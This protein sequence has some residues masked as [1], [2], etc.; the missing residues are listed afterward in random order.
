MRLSVEFI[1]FVAVS[2]LSLKVFSRCRVTVGVNGKVL[3][4]V[5]D[6]SAEC[7]VIFLGVESHVSEFYFQQAVWIGH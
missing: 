2:V 6:A 3:A 7:K 5:H 4:L 1:E